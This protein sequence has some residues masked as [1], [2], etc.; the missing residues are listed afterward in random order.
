[1]ANQSVIQ[2]SSSEEERYKRHLSLSSVGRVGQERLKASRVLLAGLGGL[3]S[4]ASMYLA[5]AGVGTIGIVEFDAVELSNL[6][7]QTLYS[8]SDVGK[9]KLDVAKV[10]LSSLNPHVNVVAHNEKLTSMNAT[11]I[12]ASYDVVIDGTDNFSTRYAIND[13]CV[14]LGI[15]YVYGSVYQN[16]GQVSVFAIAG[17]PCYRCYMPHAPAVGTVPTCVEGGVLGVLPGIIGTIQATEA[18]KLIL[19][20][21]DSLAGRLLMLDA[22]K[23]EF[24]TVEIGRDSDCEVCGDNSRR[25]SNRVQ[26]RPSAVPAPATTPNMTDNE[27]DI[28]V[29]ELAAMLQA[30][31]PMQLIDVR[32]P[33]ELKDGHI[34][35][36]TLIP[37]GELAFHVPRLRRDIVTVVYCHSGVRSAAAAYQLRMA[38]FDKVFNLIGGI[39]A[40][41]RE[42]GI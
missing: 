9:Q 25:N 32:E 39:V 42:Q 29:S 13:A 33:V 26:Q 37:M 5:A 6:Q 36:Y 12:L 41:N 18:I 20:V 14:Q 21:G 34:D 1:M 22:L 24:L 11:A 31:A 40:W 15:P 23:L 4:P 7:R 28:S 3:G 17:A 27:D 2:L 19:G 8:T 10:R 30:R 38:G 35:G 16:E